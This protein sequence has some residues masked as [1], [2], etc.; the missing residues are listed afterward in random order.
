MTELHQRTS[1]GLPRATVAGRPVGK[2]LLEDNPMEAGDWFLPAGAG[3]VIGVVA[4]DAPLLPLQTPEEAYRNWGLSVML[5][6]LGRVMAVRQG[7]RS[8]RRV[9]GEH[10]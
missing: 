6:R 9:R 4:T 10:K 7:V 5:V 8:G 1:A 3:S 2:W